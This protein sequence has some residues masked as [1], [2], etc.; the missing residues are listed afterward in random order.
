VNFDLLAPHYR[1]LE[2]LAFGNQLQEA[3]I[4]FVRKIPSPRRVLIL[5]EGNGRFVTEFV[6]AHP[7]AA[8][9][10]I[11]ASER[12]IELAQKRVNA[13]QV[14]FTH[15]NVWDTALAAGTYDLIVTHFFLDCF[16]DAALCEVVEK[17]AAAATTDASWLL[18]DFRLPKSGWRRFHASLWIRAMYLFFRLTSGL[19]TRRLDAPSP[20]L[21]ESGFECVRQQQ[22]RFGM[23]KSELWRRFA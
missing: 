7:A 21:R 10:C 6:R 14:H 3:R 22:S 1:W 20:L 9:D 11:E 12:M 8:V 13:P 5:G 16:A 17:A 23:I 19:Q 15:A 4:A 18:A 2:T